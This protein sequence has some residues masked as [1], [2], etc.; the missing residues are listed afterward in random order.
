MQAASFFLASKTL[1]LAAGIA[2]TGLRVYAAKVLGSQRTNLARCLNP[3]QLGVCRVVLI[4]VVGEKVGY[5][6]QR[7]SD[8][9]R[10]LWPQRC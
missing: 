4:G 7:M 6:T 1:S 8:L 10:R 5:L 3:Q 9:L 2:A